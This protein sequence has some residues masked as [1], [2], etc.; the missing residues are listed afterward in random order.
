[1]G[2]RRRGRGRGAGGGGGPAAGGRGAPAGDGRQGPL[3]GGRH[4]RGTGRGG[5]PQQRHAPGRGGPGPGAMKVLITGGAGFVGSHLA[6]APL[7][8]G[9]EGFRL[10]DPSTGT[11]RNIEQ[12]KGGPPLPP[13]TP[14]GVTDPVAPEP[15]ARPH[16]RF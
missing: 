2:A 15:I 3:P 12:L 5:R 6:E 10:G 8:P 1:P 11:L 4:G 13:P 7:P 16:A 14:S 9:G